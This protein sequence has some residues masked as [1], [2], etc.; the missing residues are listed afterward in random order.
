MRGFGRIQTNPA[1]NGFGPLEFHFDTSRMA[2]V[3]IWAQPFDRSLVYVHR[4]VGGERG[5]L[6]WDV[7]EGQRHAPWPIVVVPEPAPDPTATGYVNPVYPGC[8]D[9]VTAYGKSHQFYLTPG[10]FYYY[11]VFE[12]LAGYSPFLS[13]N[14]SGANPNAPISGNPVGYRLCGYGGP[15]NTGEDVYNLWGDFP[16]RS[17]FTSNSQYQGPLTLKSTYVGPDGR[18]DGVIFVV[19]SGIDAKE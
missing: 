6:M 8:G 11:A 13:T 4:L 18:P 16:D 9:N 14:S 5:D 1:E 15:T 2:R 19:S 17:F 10:N 3:N 7:S 12:G